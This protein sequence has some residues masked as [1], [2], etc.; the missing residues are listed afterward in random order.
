[1]KNARSSAANE[2]FYQYLVSI[3]ILDINIVM[4]T[5]LGFVYGAC[6]YYSKWAR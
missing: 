2:D 1:M 6:E 4:L 3:Q 5:S